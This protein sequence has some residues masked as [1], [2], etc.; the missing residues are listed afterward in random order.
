M[1]VNGSC[2]PGIEVWIERFFSVREFERFFQFDRN[3]F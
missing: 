3:E 2:F 1:R